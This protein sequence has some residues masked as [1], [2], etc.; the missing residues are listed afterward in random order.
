MKEESIMPIHDSKP[1]GKNKYA[2]CARKMT[3]CFSD[4]QT[5]QW[6]KK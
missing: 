3:V 5:H 4:S 1:C 6:L 2:L